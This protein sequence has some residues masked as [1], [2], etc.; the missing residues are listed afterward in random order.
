MW[1]SPIFPIREIRTR[2]FSCRRIT[3]FLPPLCGKDTPLGYVNFCTRM[4]QNFFFSDLLYSNF[5]KFL[6][7]ARCL[8][9]PLVGC[10]GNISLNLTA[11]CIYL[12]YVRC[13]ITRT[14]AFKTYAGLKVLV[15]SQVFSLITCFHRATFLPSTIPEKADIDQILIVIQCL[16]IPRGGAHIPGA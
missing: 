6:L 7:F 13:Q 1:I 15:I 10:V 4:F 5:F 14:P 3:V 12:F 2:L 11:V 8:L 16:V 9:S